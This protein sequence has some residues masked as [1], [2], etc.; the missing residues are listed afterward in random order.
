M[1]FTFAEHCGGI[2]QVACRMRAHVAANES[3]RYGIYEVYVLSVTDIARSHL[4][5]GLFFPSK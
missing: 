2:R 1:L 4:L 5:V 3:I